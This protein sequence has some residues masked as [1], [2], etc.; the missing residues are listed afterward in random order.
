MSGNVPERDIVDRRITGAR[1]RVTEL[2]APETNAQIYACTLAEVLIDCAE[3][4]VRQIRDAD[5]T[6]ATLLAPKIADG[7][8]DLTV[9]VGENLSAI[10][11]QRPPEKKGGLFGS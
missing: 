4:L 3:A 9:V 7:L 10:A 11:A 2:P 5:D 1:Q 6:V 8:S